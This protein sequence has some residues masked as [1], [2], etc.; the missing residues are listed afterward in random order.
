M[1]QKRLLFIVTTY[2]G[3]GGH[4]YSLCTT[5]KMLCSCYDVTI[6]NIGERLSPVVEKSGLQYKF[7]YFNFRNYHSIWRVIY[8]FI[9]ENDIE[10]VHCFDVTAYLAAIVPA[11]KTI[12][13]VVLTKCGGNVPGRFSYPKIDNIILYTREDESYFKIH[14][15]YK[16]THTYFIPNRVSLFECNQNRINALI[17]EYKLSGKRIIMRIGRI[18]HYYEKTAIQTINLVRD[19][20]QIDKRFVLL[21]IGNAPEQDALNRIKGVISDKEYIFLITNS[22]FTLDAKE[23]L[24]AAECVVG[25]GRSFMEACHRNKKMLAPCKN[26]NYPILVTDDNFEDVFAHNFSERYVNRA[27]EQPLDYL[28]ENLNK[29]ANSRKWFEMYFSIDEVKE[30]YIS[31]YSS[32]QPS[33]LHMGSLV[34]PVFRSIISSFKWL[35]NL[36]K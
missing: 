16:N 27:G 5:A 2:Q 25:T 12:I 6:L 30:K 18:S 11:Y 3:T 23:L 9:I 32:I 26:T 21:L 17:G 36:Y 29:E 34:F 20:H 28:I 33:K 22:R 8:N 4:Y 10:I 24:D 13:P 19:L 1:I 35:K 31:L 7:S 14:A 15:K